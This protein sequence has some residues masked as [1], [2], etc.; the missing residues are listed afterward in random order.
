MISYMNQPERLDSRKHFLAKR[1][2]K[3]QYECILCSKPTT[4]K[5]TLYHITKHVRTIP[6]YALSL[7]LRS[8]T[9]NSLYKLPYQ[10][11]I[12]L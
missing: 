2:V 11:Y 3:E 8:T 6:L 4:R 10:K 5:R 9:H 12:T 7:A 1:T